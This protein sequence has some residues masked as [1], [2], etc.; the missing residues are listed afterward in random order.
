MS[1]YLI[2][3]IYLIYLHIN[4]KSDDDDDEG[5]TALKII[6]YG[7]TSLAAWLQIRF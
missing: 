2:G 5:I 7:G 4:Q 1:I 3:A 6:I